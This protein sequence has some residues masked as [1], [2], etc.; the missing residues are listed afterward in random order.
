LLRDKKSIQETSIKLLKPIYLIKDA[1]QECS[2]LYLKQAKMS[3]F[4]FFH[5]SSTKL[6][7][8]KVE[9]ILPRGGVGTSGKKEVAGKGGRR[10]N[11]VQ[12]NVYECM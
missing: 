7:N 4:F 12:K 8:R 9:Q 3:I 11:M 1:Y 2:Y 6:E 5:F 10:V